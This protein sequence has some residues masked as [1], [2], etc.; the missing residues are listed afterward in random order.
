MARLENADTPTSIF[1]RAMREYRA[2]KAALDKAYRVADT[3]LPE[4]SSEDDMQI[5]VEREKYRGA[6]EE[7]VSKGRS[8]QHSTPQPESRILAT[9]ENFKQRMGNLVRFGKY[10][11]DVELLRELES[12][13]SKYLD[14][15][16]SADGPISNEYDVPLVQEEYHFNLEHYLFRPSSST[17]TPLGESESIQ[18]G[19]DSFS[20]DQ[21][22][23]FWHQV[24]DDYG[25]KELSAA[26]DQTLSLTFHSMNDD[27]H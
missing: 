26:Q 18:D 23:A 24:R 6:F 7:A 2:Q 11:T 27:G 15:Q 25:L 3:Y 10:S 17:Y 12:T 20:E 9:W 1:Y 13:E 5:R 8:L 14:S 4:T 21:E 19:I 16:T 22:N